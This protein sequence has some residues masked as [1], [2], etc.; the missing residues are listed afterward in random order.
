MMKIICDLS[1]ALIGSVQDSHSRDS[2][3]DRS[4]SSDGKQK[5]ERVSFAV[6][7]ERTSRGSYSTRRLTTGVTD[8][9][10]ESLVVP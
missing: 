10:Y 9:A 1:A 2:T 6:Y 4:D 5:G 8:R 3:A 7:G